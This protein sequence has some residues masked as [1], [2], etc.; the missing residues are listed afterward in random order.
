[1]ADDEKDNT[2][3]GEADA[4]KKSKKK[5]FI[6][7]AIVLLLGGGAGGY[8]MLGGGEV[9]AE[10]AA[11]EAAEAEAAAVLAAVQNVELDPF[12]V[13]LADTGGGHYLKTTIT[14]EV[15]NQEGVDWVNAHL[16]RV[17]DGVLMLLSAKESTQLLTAR[18]K[19]SLRDEVLE[20]VNAMMEPA[21]TNAVYLTEFVVQ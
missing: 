4:P 16:P 14:L 7:L 20:E 13:N 12:L 6:I 3:G 18:G 8:V 21:K 1:M 2:E 10:A 5:L 11:K 9:D 15:A 19:F 17:R